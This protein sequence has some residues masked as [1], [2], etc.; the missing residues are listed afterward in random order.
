MHDNI[1]NRW[2]WLWSYECFAYQ[3]G[4]YRSWSRW[5]CFLLPRL[6][7]ARS[8]KARIT[9]TISRDWIPR[10]N[11]RCCPSIGNNEKD[12]GESNESSMARISPILARPETR[13]A[14]HLASFLG[15]ELELFK[16]GRSVI[17]RFT[18]SARESNTHWWMPRCF[19]I[20]GYCLFAIARYDISDGQPLINS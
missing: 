11:G 15:G 19:L 10:W 2:P 12:S 17:A 4:S 9:G 6:V 18:T 20:S 13:T 5:R 8:L 7:K 14:R 16:A 1:D 3:F